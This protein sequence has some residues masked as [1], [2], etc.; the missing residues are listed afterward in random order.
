MPN[1]L[2]RALPATIQSEAEGDDLAFARVKGIQQVAHLALQIFVTQRLEGVFGT[3]IAHQVAE[4]S[5]VIGTDLRVERSRA[6][7][8]IFE[9]GNFGHGQPQLLGQL[10]GGRLMAEFFG[11]LR[12]NTADFADF[13]HEVNRQPDGLALVGQGAFDRLLDPPRSISAQ[14]AALFRV[15][16]LHRFHQTDIALGNEVQKGK[17]VIAEVVGNLDH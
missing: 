14:L 11:H 5:V 10:L 9:V 15:E 7:R 12:G 1:F 17:P 6:H 4:S 8:H 13:I 3:V 16:T 2:E